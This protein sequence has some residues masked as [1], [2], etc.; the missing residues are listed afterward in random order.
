MTTAVFIEQAIAFNAE[1]GLE[2]IFWVVDARMDNFTISGAT[3]RAKSTLTLEQDGFPPLKGHF[4]CDRQANN[5]SANHN[6]VNLLHPL[7]SNL[8]YRC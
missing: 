8:L 3:N 7:V 2:R 5:P 6:T 4:A 1:L